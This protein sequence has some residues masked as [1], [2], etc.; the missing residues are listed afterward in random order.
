MSDF[1]RNWKNTVILE[2]VTLN[3]LAL[4]NTKLLQYYVIIFEANI[5]FSLFYSNI[6]EGFPNIF[7]G[8]H[9]IFGPFPHFFDPFPLFSKTLKL[10]CFLIFWISFHLES[11]P[12]KAAHKMLV[13]LTLGKFFCWIWQK[14]KVIL[15]FSSN[16]L[17][18][19][20]S[21]CHHPGVI[22]TRKEEIEWYIIY[23]WW[24]RKEMYFQFGP[25]HRN[26]NNYNLF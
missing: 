6:L 1:F 21:K 14:E 4:F 25:Y 9:N 23:N 22:K 8:I 10:I 2:I 24:Y 12:V 13:K 11:A 20:F 19:K 17:E 5:F 3:V 16:V 26:R 15:D 18:K 7:E